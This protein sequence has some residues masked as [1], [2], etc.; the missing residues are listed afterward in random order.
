MHLDAI[1]YEEADCMTQ[2]GDYIQF[3]ENHN[4]YDVAVKSAEVTEQIA[5][6]F[7][8]WLIKELVLSSHGKFLSYTSKELFQEFLKQRQ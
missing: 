1:K 4:Y 7:A 8:E 3:V 5:V 6:E 2:D